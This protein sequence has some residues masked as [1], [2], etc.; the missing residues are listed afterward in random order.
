[1]MKKLHAYSSHNKSLIEKSKKCYCFNCMHVMDS[2]EIKVY[3]DGEQTAL[4]PECSIDSIIPG[5]VDESLNESVISE[6]NKYWF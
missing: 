5:V 4:C 3:I 1:M 6:M 2:G